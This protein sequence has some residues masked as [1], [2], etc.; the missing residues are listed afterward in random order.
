M[1][2]PSSCSNCETSTSLILHFRTHCK[3]GKSMPYLAQCESITGW[4]I[5][6]AANYW[7]PRWTFAVDMAKHKSTFT[8]CILTSKSYGAKQWLSDLWKDASKNSP[9]LSISQRVKLVS[10]LMFTLITQG[11]LQKIRQTGMMRWKNMH[12]VKPRFSKPCKDIIV[13]RLNNLGRWVNG[14]RSVIDWHCFLKSWGT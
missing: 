5:P 3:V 1:H 12:T 8:Y 6:V 2:S 13:C 11:N 10:F 9:I 7:I 4:L 14:S